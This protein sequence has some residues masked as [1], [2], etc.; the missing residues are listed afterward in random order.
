MGDTN[1]PNLNDNDSLDNN[2]IKVEIE[3]GSFW[4]WQVESNTAIDIWTTF[5]LSDAMEALETYY[6]NY[7]SWWPRSELA[8]FKDNFWT[9]NFVYYP[10][11]SVD[12]NPSLLFPNVVY[13]DQD[14]WAMKLLEEKWYNTLLWNVWTLDPQISF[15]LIYLLNSQLSLDAINHVLWYLAPWGYVICNNY[16]ETAEDLAGN[17]WFTFIIEPDTWKTVFEKMPDRENSGPF[18]RKPMGKC[19]FQKNLL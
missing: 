1:T 3:K 9:P 11:S 15:D 8:Y 19:I 17:D 18:S 16:H 7:I 14:V 6:N 10:C 12:T 4:G 5:S 13:A 2:T